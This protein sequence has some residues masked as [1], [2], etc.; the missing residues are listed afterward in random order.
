MHINRSNPTP[1]TIGHMT[2]K[3]TFTKTFV[4]FYEKYK[5]PVESLF[6]AENDATCIKISFFVTNNLIL[7][8]GRRLSKIPGIRSVNRRDCR[9]MHVQS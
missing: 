7:E 3:M 4:R 8:F 5:I 1:S 2:R 9:E 6:C